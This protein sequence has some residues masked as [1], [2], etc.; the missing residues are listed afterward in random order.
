MSAMVMPFS[1]EPSVSLDGSCGGSDK[2]SFSWNPDGERITKIEKLPADTAL[3]FDKAPTLPP[4]Q[5]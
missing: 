5:P 4:P 1:A 2:V 3:N